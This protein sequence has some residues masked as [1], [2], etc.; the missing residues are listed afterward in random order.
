MKI[1][2][3][4]KGITELQEFL[5]EIPRGSI[6]SAVKAFGEYLL[7]DDS[8]GVRHMVPYKYV[9]RKAAYGK[10]FQSDKQRRWF[11]AALADG[12]IAPGSGPRHDTT[13]RW[14]GMSAS[15]G[16]EYKLVANN[17]AAYYTMSDEGQARQPAKV[18]H[19]KL[20]RVIANNMT[21]AFMEAV[22]AVNKWLRSKEPK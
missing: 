14:Y 20:S 6:T 16:Y 2:F 9:S 7:G 8:H 12:R 5:K 13:R 19:L 15:S 4:T 22:N 3:E 18:G 17:P 21:G 11:F 10:S 1:K